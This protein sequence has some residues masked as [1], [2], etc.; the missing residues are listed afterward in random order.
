MVKGK[1]KRKREEYLSISK[2]EWNVMMASSSISMDPH[3]IHIYLPWHHMTL[4]CLITKEFKRVQHL[5]RRKHSLNIVK[6]MKPLKNKLIMRVWTP[7]W[8]IWSSPT[9]KMQCAFFWKKSWIN[10]LHGFKFKH[11]LSFKK[12]QKQTK[13]T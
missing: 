11:K 4:M 6:K 12:K 13:L 3:V 7:K 10:K 2:C 1:N 9:C 8:K 5:E